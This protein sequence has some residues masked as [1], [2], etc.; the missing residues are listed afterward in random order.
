MKITI[1]LDSPPLPAPIDMVYFEENKATCRILD[2]HPNTAQKKLSFLVSPTKT[3]Q[4]FLEQVATQFTYD[5]FDLIL[6]A[7]NVSKSAEILTVFMNF[8]F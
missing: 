1:I 5:K 6:E 2:R 8:P 4:E 7:T 3:V